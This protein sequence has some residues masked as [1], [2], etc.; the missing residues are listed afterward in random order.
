MNRATNDRN[1][2]RPVFAAGLVVSLGLLA[3]MFV[4]GWFRLP[5]FQGRWYDIVGHVS[6]AALAL[7]SLALL[8]ASRRGA[9][10]LSAGV[11]STI[12]VLSLIALGYWVL[13]DGYSYYTYVTGCFTH[14]ELLLGISKEN[15]F[16]RALECALGPVLLFGAPLV[17]FRRQERRT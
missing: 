16:V 10:R 4:V 9:L 15:S 12:V 7:V 14:L 13:A 1:G 11:V 17:F 8:I 3:V 5:V 6:A 2:I